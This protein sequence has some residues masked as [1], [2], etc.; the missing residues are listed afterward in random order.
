L[1]SGEVVS[2][3]LSREQLAALMPNHFFPRYCF[4]KDHIHQRCGW[5]DCNFEIEWV[6]KKKGMVDWHP[7]LIDH[8][9][10]NDH[11]EIKRSW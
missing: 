2:V 9:F 7:D 4:K 11:Y 1:A 10:K 5:Q 3:S 6:V 8:I